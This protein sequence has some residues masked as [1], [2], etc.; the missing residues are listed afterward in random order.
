MSRAEFKKDS[1]ERQMFVEFWN[2]CQD[3]WVGEKSDQY[4][5]DLINTLDDFGNKYKAIPGAFA[6][7]LSVAFVEAKEAEMKR[8]RSDKSNLKELMK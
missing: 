3:Y 4:W 1:V 6:A 5:S 8:K 2:I 7:R